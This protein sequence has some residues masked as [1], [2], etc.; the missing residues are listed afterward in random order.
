MQ[1]FCC[2]DNK[3]EYRNRIEL[4]TAKKFKKKI[5][6]VYKDANVSNMVLGMPGIVII[7]YSNMNDL[8]KKLRSKTV[9]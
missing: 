3:A 7:K 1:Y 8:M 2:R 5:I 6:C 9:H 4:M